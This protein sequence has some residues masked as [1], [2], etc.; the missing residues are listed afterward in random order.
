MEDVTMDEVQ[1]TYEQA[2]QTLIAKVQ[3]DSYI[4][5]AVLL[6]SLAYDTVWR[7]S[8]ID[9]L[10]VTQETRLKQESVC[11]VESGVNIHSMLTTR[12]AF[13]RMLEGSVEGSFLHSLLVKGRMLFSREEPLAELFEARH[14]LAERDRAIQLLR[15]ASWA[16]PGLT[17]AEKWFYAK[18]DFDY[19]SFW[20][21]KCVD[22]LATIEVLLHGEIPGREVIHQALA[23]NPELFRA[24][25]T[26]LLHGQ[27]TEENLG[28]A[29]GRIQAYLH[30]HGG[31]LFA[32]V[33][34]YLREEGELR[35][36]TDINHHFSRH[37]NVESV[38]TVC[39]WLA[40]EGLLQKLATPVR[41]TDRSRVNVEEAAYFFSGEERL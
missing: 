12:S 40:D 28:K 9:L 18:R 10:L 26:E 3:A 38:D 36:M 32:P 20:I 24:I 23:Y 34:S 15:A 17:K 41:L 1:A 6:G 8:D 39:E 29:L 25:Y 31:I 19:C 11:L 2:L 35:S 5:A 37:F 7:R 22:A 14:R 4:L 33:L 21:L 27:A 16:L 30:T 13:R